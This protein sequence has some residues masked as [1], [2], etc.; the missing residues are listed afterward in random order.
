MS[1]TKN[2]PK[3]KAGGAKKAAAP[4]GGSG[5]P[6]GKDAQ[7]AARRVEIA[8]VDNPVASAAETPRMQQRYREITAD[9][10][11]LDGILRDGAEAVTPIADSTIE[12]VKERMG[13][14]T[15]AR[16]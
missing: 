6:V 11:Y 13:L 5:A 8:G 15:A 12:L 9:P 3:G 4:R 2:Q 10:A 14:Y 16:R 7:R 1:G